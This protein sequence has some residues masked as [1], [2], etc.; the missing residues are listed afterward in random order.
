MICSVFVLTVLS[1]T[2]KTSVFI[3]SKPLYECHYQ[4]RFNVVISIRQ[5]RAIKRES[6]SNR[7]LKRQSYMYSYSRHSESLGVPGQSTEF[8]KNY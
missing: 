3:Y 2:G 8:V 4:G 5:T 1:F 7:F 6:C